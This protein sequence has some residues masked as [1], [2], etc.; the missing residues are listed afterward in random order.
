MASPS[1][2]SSVRLTPAPTSSRKTILASTSHEY[3]A[4]LPVAAWALGRLR[5]VTALPRLERLL[6]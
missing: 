4:V 2:L 1:V 3:R 5:H 6:A